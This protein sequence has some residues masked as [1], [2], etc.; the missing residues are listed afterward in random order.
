MTDAEQFEAAALQVSDTGTKYGQH[1]WPKRAI[2]AYQPRFLVCK[3]YSEIHFGVPTATCRDIKAFLRSARPTIHRGV[4]FSFYTLDSEPQ[5]ITEFL[6]DG[7][8]Y[9]GLKAR[10]F[11]ARWVA[12]E[13]RR[14]K[15]EVEARHHDH[16]AANYLCKLRSEYK[17]R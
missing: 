10:A 13:F 2:D 5:P 14:H 4:V 12:S 11:I 8:F 3:H 1:S 7:R 6:F 15:R 16:R 9:R 17:R